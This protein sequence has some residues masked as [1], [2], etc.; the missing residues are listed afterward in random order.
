MS[1]YRQLAAI[2][3]TD[4]QGYTA[5]MQEDENA[6]ITIREKY[7]LIFK[8]IT[9]IYDGKILQYY[10]DGTLSIFDSAIDAVKC[11]MDMQLEYLK[12]PVIPVRIGIHS[13][14]I[15]YS[16]EEVIG[17]GVNVA[18]RIESL[19][20]AGSV[21]ISEMIYNE[22]KNQRQI[23]TYSLGSFDLKNVTK[24][25]EVYAISNTGLVVPR[26][27]QIKGKISEKKGALPKISRKLLRRFILSTA[28]III[29]AIAGFFIY[30]RLDIGGSEKEI[31]FEKSIAVLPFVNLGGDPE[32]EYFS[33]GMRDEILTHL[34]KIGNLKVTSGTSSMQYKGINKP[35]REIGKELG[36]AYILEGSVR[37]YEDNVRISVRLI[38]VALDENLWAENYD[39]ELSN[40]F[41]IQMDIAQ[42]VANSLKVKISPEEKERIEVM[43][44]TNIEAYN[45]Y[46]LANAE[47]ER[48]FEIGISID[49]LEKAISLDP[50]FGQAYAKLGL[51]WLTRGGWASDLEPE[52]FLDKA[53]S[54]LEKAIEIDNNLPDI[55]LYLSR[56]YLWYRWDFESAE[57]EIKDV[58]RLN[59]PNTDYVWTYSNILNALGRS[60]EALAIAEKTIEDFPKFHYTIAPIGLSY[61]F[62]GQPEKA[63][64][65]YETAI[66]FNHDDKHLMMESGRIF[67]YTGKYKEAINILNRFLEIDPGNRPPHIMGNLAIAYYNLGQKEKTG[68]ILKELKLKSDTTSAG[69]PAMFTAMVYAEMGEIDHAFEWLEKAYET[70]EV[71]MYWLKVQPPFEP[72]HKDPRWQVMLD[73]VGF[74]EFEN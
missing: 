34:Y 17:D 13:G 14:D 12:D 45:L 20:V 33:D 16:D 23:H 67:T 43:P 59:P 40:I 21:L 51:Y 74:P 10:G 27:A 19:A 69:S 11:S 24:Q 56:V 61:Y 22:I 29:L 7:R 42:Q 46:L 32:Q 64:Q 8:R 58:I 62:A 1:H 66:R 31:D 2:I 53:I 57:K 6:A 72:L 26:K 52:Q 73:R 35:I 65:F 50:N 63:I 39:K 4:I 30:N 55:H 36:V 25:I 70:H 71:E 68:S 18:S 60:K 44:T 15:I 48:N 5:M 38:D 54:Y 47:F 41:N 49:L 3:F 28:L 37:R 9:E